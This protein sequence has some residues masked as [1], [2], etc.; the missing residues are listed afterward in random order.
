MC[1]R[2]PCRQIAFENAGEE[3]R[4]FVWL[5]SGVAVFADSAETVE[6]RTSFGFS[7]I[8]SLVVCRRGRD[9]RE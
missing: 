3:H 1:M 6:A 7:V 9:N 5:G 2:M 4:K 8:L